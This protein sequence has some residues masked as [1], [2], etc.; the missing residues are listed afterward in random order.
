MRDG[1]ITFLRDNQSAKISETWVELC[2]AC[3]LPDENLSPVPHLTW[4][5]SGRYDLPALC[6]RLAAWCS[7]RRSFWL[8]AAGLGVFTAPEPVLYI[9]VL[10]NPRLVRF[11]QD[12][13]RNVLPLADLPS[14]YYAPAAWMPHITLAFGNLEPDVI[15]CAVQ[16]LAYRLVTIDFKVDQLILVHQDSHENWNVRETFSFGKSY[17]H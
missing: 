15:G 17:E 1:I 4:H 12:L 16:N 11:H 9:P 10:K 8:R 6:E 5:I 3:G 14:E 13:I 7:R 2:Q